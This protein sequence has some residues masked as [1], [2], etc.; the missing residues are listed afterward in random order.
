MKI[1]F[2]G[3]AS[4]D[5][6]KK[7]ANVAFTKYKAPFLDLSKK[8]K[9]RV[10]LLVISKL[11]IYFTCYSVRLFIGKTTDILTTRVHEYLTL[12]TGQR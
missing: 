5:F 7:M 4:F 1:Y 11:Y 9:Y 12:E 10:P 2:I 3:E 8:E 6:K